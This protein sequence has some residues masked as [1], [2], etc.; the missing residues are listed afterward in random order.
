[1]KK[2]LIPATAVATFVLTTAV[3]AT[4]N[5]VDSDAALAAQVD[6]LSAQTQQLQQEITTLKKQQALKKGKKGKKA[7]KE[8]ADLASAPRPSALKPLPLDADQ[9]TI[10]KL[11][12]HYIT[13]TTVPFMT[14]TLAFNGSD[15]LYNL[16]SMNEDLALLQQKQQ[17]VEQLHADGIHL[18]RPVLQV[19]GALQGQAYSSQ[20]FNP[21]GANGGPT[22]GIALSTAELDFNAMAS[23]WATAFMAI[24]YSGSPISTGNRLP[25]SEIY[26][27]RGFL[28][29]GN[30][31]VFPMYFT[32]GKMYPPYGRYASSMVS[33]PVTQSLMEILSPAALLGFSKNNFMATAYT[34]EGAQIKGSDSI[35]QQG[36]VTANYKF[37]CNEIMNFTVGAGWVS[38]IADS[39]GMQGTGYSTVDNQF[40]G[41]G[42]N[43]SDNLAHSV[44]GGDVNATFVAGPVTLIGEYMMGLDTFSPI[45]L[46]FDG[47]G[48]RPIAS[49][50]EMDY[51][52]PFLPTKYATTLG[53]SYDHTADS[54][55]LNLEKNKYAI[56]LNTSLLRETVE[57]IEY[58]YQ[59]DYAV[60][61]IATGNNGTVNGLPPQPILGTGK[62]VNTVLF[63][64]GVFF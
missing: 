34:Y 19:S 22:A 44:N 18:D 2:F 62:G 49:R 30:L 16:S 15:L 1:M 8:A 9:P 36:G 4:D 56:F 50:I 23:S 51:M 59:Q 58:N 13:I 43:G 6:A 11:W 32:I 3:F 27:S 21:N 12:D 45:D 63:Q 54:L 39:Q 61:D 64:V 33:T 17:V 7:K 10:R 42:S 5:A 20:S 31:D 48:A 35:F 25:N 57:S 52:L 28:T 14:R 55:A 47:S 26:L 40:S 53:L 37:I 46:T 24:D 60:T 38:N 41:F 29:L